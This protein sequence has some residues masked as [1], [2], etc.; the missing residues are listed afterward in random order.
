MFMKQL[1][2]GASA[3]VLAMAAASAAYAQETTGGVRG[4]VTDE[5]GAPVANATVTI[6]HQPTGTTSTAVTSADGLYNARNLRVGGPYLVTVAAPG[7]ETR[8][9]AVPAIG[10]GDP[11]QVNVLVWTAGATELSEIVITGATPQ[12]LQTGPRTRITAT[13][14]DT[15]PSISRD[16]K[17]FVRTSPFATLDPSNNDALIIGGQSNRVNA[18][19]IDG[20]RQGDDFGLQAN[21]Y[22]T[23]NSP[24]SLS[25]VEAVTVDVAP[26]DVQYSQFQGGVV[27]VVTRSGGNDF[28]GEAFYETTN[29]GLRGDSFTFTDFRLPGATPQTRTVSGEFEET[30]WGVTFSG[31]LIRDRLFFLLNYEKFEATEPV[32]TGPSGSGAANEV[33][34][35][36]QADVD[37]VR[38]IVQSVYGF[39]PLD[40]A[41]DELLTEDEKIFARVDWNIN[42]NHRA[43]FS[44]QNTTGGRISATGTSTSFTSPSLGLL[45]KWYSLDTELTVYKAQLFSDWSDNFSTE[46]SIGRKEV[47]NVSSPLG[48]DAF[49]EFRVYL[50]GT[51]FT[52]SGAPVCTA[53]SPCPSIFL[54]PD[55]SRHAN[56]LTN[57]LNQYRFAAQYTWGDH[58]FSAGFEREELEIF[59]LF[60]QRANGQYVFNSLADLQNREAASLQYASAASNV[61]TD[62]AAS[63]GYA[64]NTLYAQDEYDVTPNLTVRLGLRYDWYSQDDRPQEN[65]AFEAAYGFSNTENLDGRGALQPRIGFTWTPDELTTIYGGA[66]LF[67]GG[68]PNVW[69]SN[70]WSNTGNLLGF[71]SCNRS[72]Q[73]AVCP[74][75]LDNVDGFNVGVG[76]QTANTASANAGTGN[77]NAIDPSFEIPS[78]WKFSLGAERQ[79]NFGD[80]DYASFLGD[81]WRF[82]AEAVW[83]DTRRGVNWRDLLQEANL[84]GAAPD[85]RPVYGP[86]ANRQDMVLVNTNEGRAFQWAVGVAREW[87]S[88]WAEGLDFDLSYTSVDSED[89]NPGTSSVATSNYRQV[90]VAYPNNPD[91]A[92]SNYEIAEATK[93]SI[94]YRRNF[95]GDYRSSVRLFAQRRSGLP[96]SYTFDD[97]SAFG[98]STGMFGENSLYTSTDR[99]LLYVPAT[100]GGVVTAS[101]D[102]IVTFAP[103]FN[104]SAFNDFL[105]QTGLIRY[106]GQ[107]APRNAFRSPDVTTVDVRLAQE[108]PAF[109][110]NGA[111]VELYADIENLG[112][113]INDEWGVLQQTGFPYMSANVVARNCQQAAANCA[114]GVGDFYQFDSFSNRSA[115]AFSGQSVW[116]VKLG[117]RYRF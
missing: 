97:S 64:V 35:I 117:V 92:T 81:G 24:I 30:T 1:A 100:A 102:P 105:N 29:D 47:S 43:V 11:A 84:V 73:A 37:T 62:G 71:V 110:P 87:T 38:G 18:L 86:R 10:I 19:M 9:V 4:Q 72:N 5:T 63:F 59:N 49:A 8:E 50:P 85:G 21:G 88:G 60:V 14:I 16:I 89:V 68:S 34:G 22:P 33:P 70:N 113:M 56:V 28:S 95:F 69:I 23:Q 46:I 39:D 77:V 55:I 52:G 2:F 109:F 98:G 91:L 51:T 36:T 80:W 61:K 31:P 67:I 40:W 104:L 45:S 93:L 101:S 42:D 6:R 79:V 66:G 7:F 94:G 17:D 82:R 12:G 15:L 44:Y 27:N 13:D 41:Q 57:D 111:R 26:F 78:V 58:R 54:G 96:F 76:A 83:S 99:Q 75:A 107:I 114:A 74:G 48:G 116:Q 103:G 115:S 53:V 32:L 25:V 106:A 90:A 20:V 65:P 112:N 108:L 3:A